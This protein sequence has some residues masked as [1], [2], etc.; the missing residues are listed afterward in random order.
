ME[1]SI[2][3]SGPVRSSSFGIALTSAVWKQIGC[4]VSESVRAVLHIRPEPT[5]GGSSESCGNTLTLDVVEILPGA[6]TGSA[7]PEERTIAHIKSWRILYTDYRRPL[8][9]FEQTITAALSLYVFKT[10]L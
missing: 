9:T 10:T 4:A 7:G 3:Q 5:I 8:H 2:Y 1:R 6:S